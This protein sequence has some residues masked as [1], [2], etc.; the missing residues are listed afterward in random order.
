[1]S[2]R[3]RSI[4]KMYQNEYNGDFSDYGSV[5]ASVVDQLPIEDVLKAQARK[6]TLDLLRANGIQHEDDL[7]DVTEN[8]LTFMGISVVERRKV[9]ART[10]SLRRRKRR[11]TAVRERIPDDT[12]R[13]SHQ[14]ASKLFLDTS[15]DPSDTPFTRLRYSTYG[16]I[17]FPVNGQEEREEDIT[18]EKAMKRTASVPT[19]K[20]RQYEK[21]IKKMVSESDKYLETKSLDSVG[22]TYTDG[23]SI[24]TIDEPDGPLRSSTMNELTRN[25]VN[26]P[27]V[28]ATPIEPE[29]PPRSLVHRD[30]SMKAAM[31]AS[32]GK[33]KDRSSPK[34]PL[35]PRHVAV[36][37]KLMSIWHAHHVLK[38][39][40][41]A[42]HREQISIKDLR[43]L[44][45]LVSQFSSEKSPT[46][47]LNELDRI[48]SL[49]SHFSYKDLQKLLVNMYSNDPLSIKTEELESEVWSEFY[50]ARVK[51][52]AADLGISLTVCYLL[53]QVFNRLADEQFSPPAMPKFDMQKVLSKC[54]RFFGRDVPKFTIADEDHFEPV[55]YCEMLKILWEEARDEK[56]ASGK[57]PSL[58]MAKE[59]NTV[60][61]VEELRAGTLSK[62]VNA[63]KWN[64]RYFS[65]VPF[66]LRWWSNSKKEGTPRVFPLNE[67]TKLV[68][69]D[70]KIE[71]ISGDKRIRL[72]GKDA[73]SVMKWNT[74]I[75]LVYRAHSTTLT[76]RQ[77]QIM[78]RRYGDGQ[79]AE[80]SIHV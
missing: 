70:T 35:T 57:D 58:E 9:L 7:I 24:I 13:Q 14:R 73:K 80:A 39:E 54:A 47:V 15:F 28:T 68:Q 32:S 11:M 67:H 36:S 69:K 31:M 74:A 45:R 17:H 66:E 71:I 12:C 77:S 59:L 42:A 75:G 26:V 29:K 76:P 2:N 37:L 22:D 51:S 56:F 5:A 78:E 46:K 30:N 25:E 52:L 38:C 6:T 33:K 20:P 50:Q 21:N 34:S 27:I 64:K 19:A 65:V 44:V 43:K 55:E 63:F 18:Q 61:V 40:N 72:K 16:P 79:N 1:L 3:L 60:F 4:A 23:E 53:W 10:D 41:A 48:H 62:R 8:Q 49:Q